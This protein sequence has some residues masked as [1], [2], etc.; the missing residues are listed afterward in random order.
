MM[1]KGIQLEPIVYALICAAL[2]GYRVAAHLRK[3]AAG[4]GKGADAIV[5]AD[6]SRDRGK[7]GAPA[8]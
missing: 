7:A 3:K 1:R 4:I 6:A 5:A 8:S 2:L